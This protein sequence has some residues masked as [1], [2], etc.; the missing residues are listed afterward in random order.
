MRSVGEQ[1]GA[2]EAWCQCLP[3]LWITASIE[4]GNNMYFKKQCVHPVHIHGL[5]V[6]FNALGLRTEAT[7]VL[8]LPNRLCL[9]RLDIQLQAS[10]LF[11]YYIANIHQ[12]S[13]EWIPQYV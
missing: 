7:L 9:G 2:A 6:V 12:F 1:L 11:I 3:C 13:Q 5:Q 8:R 4:S 10:K